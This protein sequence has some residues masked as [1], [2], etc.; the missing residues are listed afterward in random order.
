M[1]RHILLI[2]IMTLA[3]AGCDKQRDLY[4]LVSPMVYLEGN[5]IPSLGTN[6]MAMN[7]TAT[8]YNTTGESVTKEYFY[9]QNN[10]TIPVNKGEYNIMVFNGLMYSPEDTHLDNITFRGTDRLATF[11]AVARE[12]QP[13][14]RLNRAEGEYI[15]SNE[16]ELLTSAVEKQE[17]TASDAYYPKYKDGQNGFDV[18]S[19]Y[20][21]VEMTAT[22]VAMNYQCRVLLYINNISSAYSASAALRGFV[23]SAWMATRTPTNF[24]VTHQFNL[25]S[26]R[27]IDADKDRGTIESPL[28]VTFGPPVDAPNNKYEVYIKITLVDNTV[29]ETTVDITQQVLPVIETI[30]NN[31]SGAEPVQHQLNIPIQIDSIDLPKVE[32]VQGGVGVGDWDDDEII[33]VPIKA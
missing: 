24:Y 3:I 8:V 27:M 6:N 10:V 22:P 13:N 16:M 14:R 25:N 2:V 29:F 5:W 18:P 20:V 15:A 32:P 7:A 31:I 23:G 26:K 4:V 17:I 9:N 19:N 28:F 30:K 12:T 33:R 21:E 1:K 11:E